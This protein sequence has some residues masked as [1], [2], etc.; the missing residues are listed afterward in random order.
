MIFSK[1]FQVFL[2]TWC[3]HLRVCWT[4]TSR[5]E[6]LFHLKCSCPQE[7]TFLRNIFTMWSS[8][9]D[10]TLQKQWRESMRIPTILTCSKRLLTHNISNKG[11]FKRSEN[12]GQTIY[13]IFHVSVAFLLHFVAVAG[14]TPTHEI[15]NL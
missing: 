4:L 10:V 6:V 1:Y 15:T 7:T 3:R 9:M 12:R 13:P 2:G 5:I 11:K 8:C 14:V